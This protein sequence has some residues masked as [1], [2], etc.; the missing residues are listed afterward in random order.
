MSDFDPNTDCVKFSDLLA[1][2]KWAVS[3][4]DMLIQKVENAYNSFEFHI[5]F[6]AIH[7]FCVLDMSNFY[8]DVIKDR[9]YVEKS[10]SLSRRAAQTV[11]YNI[12]DAMTKMIAPILA[13]TSEEI[14]SYM[15]H[16]AGDNTGS[17]SFNQMSKPSGEHFDEAFLS[18]WERIH[19]IRDDV[20][21][22]LEL[23]RI[24]KVIGKSLEAKVT[25]FARKSFMSL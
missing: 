18:Q 20:T 1:I 8:L 9:L 12:L 15:P 4:L 10:D 23:A 21:K 16:R 17:V 3:R 19:C 2:D 14:W 22:A 5:I 24:S 11:I 13:F 7:N 25:L 6:H